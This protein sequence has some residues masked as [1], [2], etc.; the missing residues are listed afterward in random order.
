MTPHWPP[1]RAIPPAPPRHTLSTSPTAARR[2]PPP[3]AC[4]PRAAPTTSPAGRQQPPSANNRRRSPHLAR[5]AGG[6]RRI[7]TEV[8]F[9]RLAPHA[10]HRPPHLARI[11]LAGRL[12]S[13]PAVCKPRTDNLTR[14]SPTAALASSCV[15]R[16]LLAAD[17]HVFEIFNIRKAACAGP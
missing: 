12:P 7:R 2:S 8:I 4:K 13:S 15:R 10:R 16:P 6:R 5:A 17:R 1:P 3:A 9:F 14:T 11:S